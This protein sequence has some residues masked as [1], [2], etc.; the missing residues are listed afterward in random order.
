MRLLPTLLLAAAAALSPLMSEAQVYVATRDL[1][2]YGVNLK[3][4]T[5][6]AFTEAA[7]RA[8]AVSQTWWTNVGY[9]TYS[10]ENVGVPGLQSFAVVHD[11]GKVLSVQFLVKTEAEDN[12]ALR[13]LLVHKYGEPVASVRSRT[14]GRTFTGAGSPDGTY[15][16][17]FL[18]GMKLTYTQRPDGSAPTLTYTDTGALEAYAQRS[19]L[20]TAKASLAEAEDLL[21]GIVEG[22]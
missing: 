3:G 9:P 19:K 8:G 6:G 21:N 14:I 22:Y 10:V 12:E 7:S 4:S 11:A 5:L 2:L 20:E 15:E 13:A 17:Q 1:A 16:W 18:R